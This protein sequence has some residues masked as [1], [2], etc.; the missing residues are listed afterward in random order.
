MARSGVPLKRALGL[1]GLVFYGVGIILGAGIYSVIGVA[2]ARAGEA[3]WLSFAL[4]SV[5]ALVTA[6][7]YAELA[8]AHPRA[9]AEF[10]YLR[11]ALPEWPSVGLVTGLLVAL[12][13]A[14]TA[15]TVAIAFA[16]YLRTFL[17]APAVPVALGLLV[18]AAGMN[19]VGV[20]E[21]GWINAAFTLLEGGG[22]VLFVYAGVEAHPD[23]LADALSAAPHAG[24]LSGAA[25]VFF[26][27]LGFENIANLAEEA[28]RPERDVPRAILISLGVST[29][30]YVLVALAAVVLASPAALAASGAPLADAARSTSPRIAGALGGI[31]LFATANTALVSMLVASRVI[32]GIAREKELPSAL[33]ALLPRRET[34]WVA[35]LGVTVVGGAL[36][37]FGGVGVVAS[38]SSFASLLAFASVNAAL[39]VLRYREPLESRPFRV[40][41]AI[42]G[43]PVL[44][45]IGVVATLGMATQLDRDA[46]LGGAAALV[47]FAVYAA[48]HH[49]GGVR[50]A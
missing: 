17:D 14:A 31:A 19:L 45:A 27:F 10:T 44:P 40:P 9:S 49:R 6:L 38:V 5:I 25:M 47:A 23:R 7:S 41:G 50:K 3:L 26:S 1:A 21:S 36:I 30:L 18:A 16:G 48:W 13:G 2:A 12:S 42:R 43:F 29:T 4:S 20:R 15:A 28:K 22:L 35:I 24:V 32:F 39:I 33:A 11:S 37:P 34:P 8:A 46:L